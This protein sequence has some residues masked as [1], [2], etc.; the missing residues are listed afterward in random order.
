MPNYQTMYMQLAGKVA[1]ATELLIEALQQ[2]EDQFVGDEHQQQL[3]ILPNPNLK[4]KN[5]DED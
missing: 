1:D 4:G 5:S 3:L 2:G